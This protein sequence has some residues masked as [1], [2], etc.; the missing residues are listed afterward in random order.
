[1]EPEVLGALHEL[2]RHLRRRRT[3]EI[4]TKTQFH[5]AAKLPEIGKGLTLQAPPARHE[6][7]VLE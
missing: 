4:E 5:H 1:M 2:V 3:E 7:N 6:N